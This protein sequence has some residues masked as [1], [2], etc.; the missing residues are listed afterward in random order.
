MKIFFFILFCS[1]PFI[2]GIAQIINKEPLSPRE[3][4]Y[5][6]SAVL[7]PDSNIVTGAMR[8]YW[9][10]SSND[11]VPDIRLHLYM[12]AFKNRNSTMNKEMGVSAFNDKTAGRI[13]ITKFTDNSGNDLL[14][15]LRFI[16]PDDGNPSDQTVADIILPRPAKPGDTVF[17]NIDFETKLPILTRRTGYKDDFYFVAQWFPKF[18]VY[19]K[20]GMRYA[21]SGGWNC[22]QFHANSEFYAN[23]SLYDVTITVPKEYVVGTGGMLM[24]AD[25]AET[26]ST[27]TLTY[28]AEDIVDFAWTAWPWL[29]KV[30]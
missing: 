18:G 16:S 21:T 1:L 6:I 10:N 12:N 11:I 3:T 5:R 7:D 9:V 29:C 30:F 14:S 23:H 27:K 26:G 28:R 25:S 2:Q 19:E 17:I 4:N 20:T 15:S 22:H 8:A 13:D 24:K